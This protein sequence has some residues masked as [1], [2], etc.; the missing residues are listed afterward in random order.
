MTAADLGD[1][2]SLAR[3]LANPVDRLMLDISKAT[4][5]V[6]RVERRAPD[7]SWWKQKINARLRKRREPL[8]LVIDEAH[9]LPPDV[10]HVLL[11]AV[12]AFGAPGGAP[13]ALLLA[14][15]P[16]LRPFLL[17]DAVNASFVEHAPLIVPGL[18][19]PAASREALDASDWRGWRRDEAVLD[20]GRRGQPRLSLVSA[21]LGPSPVG[22]GACARQIVDQDASGGGPRPQVDAVRADFYSHRYDEFENARHGGK[23]SPVTPCWT[24]DAGHCG[25]GRVR[26][27]RLS[28]PAE[29]NRALD[30]ARHPPRRCQP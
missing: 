26:R 22:R 8:L 27:A 5:G 11:N 4:I 29:L 14:G 24:A 17:S 7:L 13:V 25:P 3:E 9:A 18:L 15:T 23:A 16:G 1:L 12:Q 30:E 21:A 19:S 2:P 6:L 10:A 28:A 20:D